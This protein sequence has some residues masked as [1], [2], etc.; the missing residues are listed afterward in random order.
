MTVTKMRNVSQYSHEIWVTRD[1]RDLKIGEMETSHLFFCFRMLYNLCASRYGWLPLE[2]QSTAREDLSE[3]LV[4]QRM[5][6]FAT[7]IVL[8]GDLPE[9]HVPYFRFMMETVMG[10]SPSHDLVETITESSHDLLTY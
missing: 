2:G 1:G 5:A 3:E 8:R 9:E 6:W 7:D 10:S 4:A